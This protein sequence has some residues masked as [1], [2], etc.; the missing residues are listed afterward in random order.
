M[1]FGLVLPNPL[2][3]SIKAFSMKIS[4]SKSISSFLSSQF[5]RGDIEDMV[6]HDFPNSNGHKKRINRIIKVI[7]SKGASEPYKIIISL[8]KF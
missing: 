4:S 7:T 3:A 6:T 8:L 1:G 2:R 5:E